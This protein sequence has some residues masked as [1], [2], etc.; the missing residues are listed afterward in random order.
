MN[1]APKGFKGWV[2]SIDPVRLI[3]AEHYF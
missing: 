3:T 2:E 1:E